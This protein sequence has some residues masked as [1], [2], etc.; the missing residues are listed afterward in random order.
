MVVLV[1]LALVLRRWWRWVLLV[2]VAAV[3]RSEQ[4][5]GSN[6]GCQSAV[7]FHAGGEGRCFLLPLGESSV[8]IN[9]QAGQALD[10]LIFGNDL[11]PQLFG[12]LLPHA[13]QPAK[14]GKLLR[15]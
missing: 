14:F 7:N 2:A 5:S 1:V 8:E 13:L 10:F 3:Q 15:L 6:G 12:L 11:S 4:T 9:H